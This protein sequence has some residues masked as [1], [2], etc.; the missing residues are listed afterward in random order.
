MQSKIKRIVV[1]GP[2]ILMKNVVLITKL[3]KNIEII[4]NLNNI[5]LDGIGICGCC[6]VQINNNIKYTCIDGP[7]FNGRDVNFDILI[8]KQIK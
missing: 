5:I 4:V 3:L 8:K 2:V 6:R 7:E 1:I